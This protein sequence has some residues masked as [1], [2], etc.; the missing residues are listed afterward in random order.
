MNE[1]N[2]FIKLYRKLKTWGWYQDSIVKCVFL[3]LLLSANFKDTPWQG[4]TLKRGQVV[5]GSQRI[6]SE[7]GFSRQQVRTALLKLEST[8]EITIEPTNKY[9]VITVVNWGDYQSEEDNINQQINQNPNQQITNNQPTKKYDILSNNVEC[10]KMATNKI[11]N[12]KE[13]ENIDNIGFFE[14]D[15]NLSTNT[16]TNNQP[17]NNQQITNKQPQRKNNKEYK[18]KRNI[19]SDIFSAYALEDESLLN[20]LTD[21]EQMRKSI[22]K[23]LTDRAKQMLCKKLDELKSN[24]EDVIACLE[25]AI[26]HNWL[27]VYPIR[28]KKKENTMNSAAPARAAAPDRKTEL[29]RSQRLIEE[30]MKRLEGN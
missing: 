8:N 15:T 4:R 25:E 18:N 23:P 1:L 21:F 26:L 13:P 5:I 3:H 19:D 11:T 24:G 28:E 30:R 14:S 6:A 20:T 7:L 16:L 10:R 29:E 12:K 2:G 9:S 27:T 22:K 17:T